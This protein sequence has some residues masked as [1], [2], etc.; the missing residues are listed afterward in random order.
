MSED[1]RQVIIDALMASAYDFA[2]LHHGRI[3]MDAN[4]A[5]L[6]A[7]VVLGVVRDVVAERDRLLNVVE[8]VARHHRAGGQPFAMSFW[9]VAITMELA[10]HPLPGVRVSPD[11][12]DY[13]HR[14]PLALRAKEG[15]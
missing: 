5:S 13:H 11:A 10:G 4:A 2:H 7:D 1:T 8:A 12:L 15:T 9:N 3:R 14:H 6:V